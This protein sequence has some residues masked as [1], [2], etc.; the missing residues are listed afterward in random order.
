MYKIVRLLN[1]LNDVYLM[2]FEAPR[3]AKAYK[4]GQFVIIRAHEKGERVPFSICDCSKEKGTITIV[5]KKVG[6]TTEYMSSLKVNDNLLDAAGPLGIPSKLFELNELKNKKVLFVSEGSAA[7]RIYPELQYLSTIENKGDVLLKF[8]NKKQAMFLDEIKA[9]SSRVDL[10]FEDNGKKNFKETL[11]CILTENDYSAVVCMGSV[12]MMKEASR[13]TKDKNVKII[14]SLNV[15]MLDGTGMCGAC[16]VTV[17][18]EVKFVCTDGPEFDGHLIDFD[19]VARRQK[20]YSSE[21][22]KENYRQQ[23]HTEEEG[24]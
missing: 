8:K 23:F 18:N 6:K 1:V 15:L 20:V 14:V 16:R 7:L 17:G 13:I 19:E 5:F 24:C 2:E 22:A 10:L 21:T 12:N 3:I 4:P 11:E 9:V